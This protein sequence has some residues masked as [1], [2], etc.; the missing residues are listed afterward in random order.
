MKKLLI[1]KIGEDE[2]HKEIY[3]ENYNA[4][5]WDTN[6]DDQDGGALYLSI[7]KSGYKKPKGLTKQDKLTLDQIRKK[8]RGYKELNTLKD[9]SILQY[10]QPFRAW[11]RYY[12]TKKEKFRI[13][14]L[15]MKAEFPNYITLVNTANNISWS[16]QLKDNIIYLPEASFKSAKIKEK[17][18]NKM[19]E[20]PIKQSIDKREKQK[21]PNKQDNKQ[22]KEEQ[23]DKKEMIKDKLYDLFL[24]GKLKVIK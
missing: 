19:N 21:Q 4:H 11:I 2:I 17:E 24:K 1:N 7:T 3:K 5:N 22:N 15:L 12:D 18:Q 9:K 23:N 16:V 13:G 8:I 10:V 14:G 20:E 6:D